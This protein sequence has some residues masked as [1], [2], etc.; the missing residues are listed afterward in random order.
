MDLS[1][2]KPAKSSIKKRK[3]L[4]RGQGSS[5]GGTSTR[6]HKGKQSR[7]GYSR[8]SCF[9]GGQQPLQRRVPKFGFKNINRKEYKGINLDTLQT[10]CEKKKVKKNESFM[11]VSGS[12]T[13]QNTLDQAGGSALQKNTGMVRS[14][15]VSLPRLRTT[16]ECLGSAK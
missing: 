10:L 8:K 3:R 15:R 9:E 7:S 1:N 4:G 13:I 16:P 5:R 2:W 12:G 6:G 11:I 14:G